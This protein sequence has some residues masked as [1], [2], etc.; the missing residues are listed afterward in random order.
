MSIY[1]KKI[2]LAVIAP[3]FSGH[4]YPI[5]ELILPLLEKKDKYDI[6]VY[7]GFQKEKVVK[8]LG[9]SVKVLLKDK[10]NAFEK[11]SDTD[12]QTNP[13]I[14]YKQ[15]KENMGLMPEIIKEIE[16]FF[17]E[18]KPDIVLA[19]FIAVPVS[20][21]CKNFNIPWITSIP[22]PFAIESKTT[23]PAYVTG[24]YPREN[25]FFK[26]RDKLARSLVKNFKRLVCFILRKQLK[27]LNFTLYNEKGEESIYSPY[28]IL[29]L[30]M[31][32][33][34]FRD[35]FPSHFLWA[36]PCCSSLFQDSVEFLN[37]KNLEK[38]I[39][40]TNGT[41]LKWAKNLMVDIAKELSQKYP[42]Y[43]FVVSLGSYLERGKEIIKE[44]N[45]H[46]YHYLDYDEI[47]RKIDYVIHHGGAG[48][49]YSCIKYNKPA[50]I[51]PHDYDQFDYGVRADLAKIG[52]VAKLK[53]RK[54]I[55]R[56]FDIMINKREWNNLEK[57]SKDFN[58]YSPSELLEKEINR[59]LKGGE[60]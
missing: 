6:S 8:K 31:K 9:F 10:P 28:S 18:N 29:G 49:L 53:S 57:L 36:G 16:T 17:T 27:E 14:A 23:T 19:D 44:N 58:R 15:F 38:T 41:H 7:T 43:L 47:L 25:F 54:S 60:Q 20:F 1:K 26:F 56:A 35:D 51:I 45:L 2:K 3:P 37:N 46:I 30:G 21:V 55:L 40:L 12:R 50:V 11:I 34:E 52:I 39:F 32:E 59:L 42:Q 4:I 22:T 13:L 33:L 5:L 24:L 48:I